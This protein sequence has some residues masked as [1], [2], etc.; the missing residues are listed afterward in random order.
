MSKIPEC[1]DTC[2][3]CEGKYCIAEHQILWS[4]GYECP[5]YE[6]KDKEGNIDE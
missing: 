4:S 3:K 5:H 1:C 6:A 2:K